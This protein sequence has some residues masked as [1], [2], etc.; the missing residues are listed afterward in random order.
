MTNQE[1]SNNTPEDPEII[2]ENSDKINKE[3]KLNQEN[4]DKIPVDVKESEIIQENF[5]NTHEKTETF[6]ENS[7]KIPENKK[8]TENVQENKPTENVQENLETENVQENKETKNILENI[9]T[10]NVQE[11]KEPEQIPV[12]ENIPSPSEDFNKNT[13]TTNKPETLTHEGLDAKI[14]EIENIKLLGNNCFR[15]KNLIKAKSFYE[16]G[17]KIA[18]EEVKKVKIFAINNPINSQ[19]D[20]KIEILMKGNFINDLKRDLWKNIGTVYLRD[21]NFT[22]CLEADLKVN[23]FNYIGF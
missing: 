4:S 12:K 5:N 15:E 6:Q 14:R 22:L 13:N 20:P 7:D 3:Q 9:E 1:N 10:E 18:R 2:E 8:E 23:Y 19:F 16:E 11:K 21:E 17:I